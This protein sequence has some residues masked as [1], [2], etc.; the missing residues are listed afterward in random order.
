MRTSIGNIKAAR[1]TSQPT[2]AA[3]DSSS[4]PLTRPRS[5]SKGKSVLNNLKGLFSGKRDVPPTPGSSG[6]R[7]SIGSRKSVSME[8]EDIPDVPAVPAVPSVPSLPESGRKS[9]T[10]SILVKKTAT[11][12]VHS[13]NGETPKEH[14]IPPRPRRKST[15]KDAAPKKDSVT[16]GEEKPSLR[17]KASK[18]KVS[19]TD[20]RQEADAEKEKRDTVALMEMG[21]ALRQEAFKE[22]DLVRKERMTSFAQVMLDTVTNAVEAER[23]MYA[24][25]QAA[26]Q[27]KMS[28]MMTQQSVQEMNKLVST[29]RRL[30]LFKKKKRPTND[31]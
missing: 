17:R 28:Y 8:P 5:E 3:R 18:S 25:M 16:S 14:S 31:A 10:K 30:P 20:T 29:S 2:E 4:T 24:A 22:D 21:L 23:N 6:R 19:A 1:Q 26:E 27:A 13:S 7:F 9:T 12:E 15:V 11:E